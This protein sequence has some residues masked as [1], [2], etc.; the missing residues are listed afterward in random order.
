MRISSQLTERFADRD[1]DPRELLDQSI[2]AMERVSGLNGATQKSFINVLS[3]SEIK[4]YKPPK[5]MI[6]IGDTHFV[7]GD[8]TIIG[9]PP[10]VG[11]S[12]ALVAVAQSGATGKEWMGYAGE[13]Q[14]R[15]LIIQN[16][17]GLLRLQ[18]ELADINEPKLEK[19]LRISEPPPFGMC[20]WR[21]EFRDQLRKISETFGPQLV[22]LDPWN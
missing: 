14:F 8:V 18:R 15:T 11:K 3:P 4:Q 13:N 7:R 21:S 5:D 19:C 1:E 2:E 17:N 20:F 22:G 9:G 6:L 10:G 16:E 12:R